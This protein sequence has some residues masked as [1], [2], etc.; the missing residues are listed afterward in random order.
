M[1][2]TI[3][4]V[5]PESLNALLPVSAIIESDGWKDISLKRILALYEEMETYLRVEEFLFKRNDLSNDEK[6]ILIFLDAQRDGS[7]STLEIYSRYIVDF[8]NFNKKLFHEISVWDVKAYVKSKREQGL[9]PKSVNTMLAAVKSFYKQVVG[10]GFMQANPAVLVKGEKRNQSEINATILEKALS[11][12]EVM[13]VLN[14]L[15][16]KGPL[17]NHLMFSMMTRMGLRAEEVCALTWRSVIKA[18]GV[19]LINVFGKGKKRRM[20]AIPDET[21]RLLMTYRRVEFFVSQNTETPVA[22]LD[23]PLFSQLRNKNKHMTRQGIYYIITKECEAAL[24]KHVH[25]H[26]L[27]HTCFTQL[28][29]LKVSMSDLRDTAGHES[30]NTTANYVGV[31][32]TLSG[33]TLAF[34]KLPENAGEGG[35]KPSE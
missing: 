1:S 14:Y 4:Q 23:M 33:A 35:Y 27:R 24:Q 15:D 9:K 19:W 31:G 21:L 32:K 2:D 20:L 7:A 10:I 16:K 8:L 11:F 17:R 12:E 18:Q 5:S 30:I 26:A 6:A 34:N 29:H 22:I 13:A 25:P 3:T 28:E